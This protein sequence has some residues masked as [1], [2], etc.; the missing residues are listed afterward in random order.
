MFVLQFS[1]STAFSL[2]PGQSLSGPPL[3]FRILSRVPVLHVL[4]HGPHSIQAAQTVMN[5]SLRCAFPNSV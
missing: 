2:P 5:E 3:Q 1:D 4:E